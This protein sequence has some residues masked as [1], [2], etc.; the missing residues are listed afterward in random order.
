MR[1]IQ[2]IKTLNAILT[3]FKILKY[4]KQ[5]YYVYIS[6]FYGPTKLF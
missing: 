2:I 4:S 1:S 6:M 3:Y 5:E